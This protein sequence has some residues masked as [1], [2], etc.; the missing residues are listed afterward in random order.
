M[1]ETNSKIINKLQKLYG[2]EEVDVIQNRIVQ[3]MDNQIKRRRPGTGMFAR[4]EDCLTEI[5]KYY[6]EIIHR[7]YYEAMENSYVINFDNIPSFV[8]MNYIERNNSGV[9]DV[10]TFKTLLK[11]LAVDNSFTRSEYAEPLKQMR[12]K[13]NYNK[14]L[15]AIARYIAFEIA[16]RDIDPVKVEIETSI[17]HEQRYTENIDKLQ[18]AMI[19]GLTHKVEGDLSIGED[20]YAS[21]RIGRR[22]SQ[23]DAV[24]LIKDNEIPDFKMMVV[25]DGMGGHENGEVA[26]HILVTELSEWFKSMPYEKKKSYF[27]DISKIE[28]EL[29]IKIDEISQNIINKTNDGGATLCCAII[30]KNNT[31]MTNIGD[32]RGYVIRNGKLEQITRDDSYVQDLLDEGSI[33][34]KKHMRFHRKNNFITAYVG[35]SR[36]SELHPDMIVLNNDA[37][38]MLMLFSDGVTDCLSDKDI[39]AVCKKTDRKKVAQLLSEKALTTDSRISDDTIDISDYYRVIHGGKDNATTAVFVNHSGKEAQQ[40]AIRYSGIFDLYKQFLAKEQEGR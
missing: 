40:F 15:N 26:S 33:K 22:G 8:Y 36:Y 37:Y 2:G 30:G 24:M 39:L 20:L 1:L 5:I 25:A 38:D 14:W 34:D 16:E 17:S 35:D 3:E 10:D 32:S 12:E 7:D 9:Y 11:Y 31:L 4:D 19:T 23:E 27:E 13:G 6:M 28:S 21:T 18:K 29:K